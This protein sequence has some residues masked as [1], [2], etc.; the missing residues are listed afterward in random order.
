MH[1]KIEG[2]EFAL[3]QFGSIEVDGQQRHT[4][5][6]MDADRLDEVVIH[7]WGGD[8]PARAIQCNVIWSADYSELELIPHWL[9]YVNEGG[10]LWL[11]PTLPPEEEAWMKQARARLRRQKAL[12]V[13]TYSAEGTKEGGSIS[14]EPL[15]ET[16]HSSVICESWPAF[17]DWVRAQQSSQV[18]GCFRG[19]GS[20]RFKLR[21]TLHRANRTRLERFARETFTRFRTHAEAV[22][23]ERIDL[24]NRDDY[25]MLMGL[26]QHH[27]LPTPMLDWTASPYIAAFFAFSD[28]LEHQDSRNADEHTHVRVYGLTQAFLTTQSS[29]VVT[30][31]YIAPYMS[32]LEISPRNNPRLY[33]Q[34]GSF[35]VTNVENVEGFI[36]AMSGDKGQSETLQSVD[37]P[38]QCAGEALE[39]LAYMGL[40]AAT[41][42]PGLDGACRAMR[43]EMLFRHRPIVPPRSLP[44]PK[45]SRDDPSSI[46]EARP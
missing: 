28:A 9:F 42:F 2:E 15:P 16:N 27:G 1:L 24:N 21:T 18:L 3:Q 6:C 10:G 32:P 33:A 20:S 41:M 46:T 35:L 13:G 44:F 8:R 11:P 26:A 7:V 43:H 23:G 17:R 34:Q 12:L 36:N 14:F 29:P 40:T 30:L 4:M 5:L 38:I 37:I 45:E 31:P 39:D 19:H 25:A 22:L